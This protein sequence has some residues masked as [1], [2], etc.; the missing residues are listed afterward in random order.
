MKPLS[1]LLVTLPLIG[2]VLIVL[3]FFQPAFSQGTGPGGT[4][5][6]SDD[7]NRTGGLG[8][9]WTTY[10]GSFTTDGT[11]AIS[12]G[13]VNWAVVNASLGTDDYD[14]EALITVPSGASY[15]GIVARGNPA[16]GFVSDLYSAQIDSSGTVNLYR[17]NNYAWT[18]LSG[19]QAG[20]SAGQPY[21]LGLRVSGANPV[22][23]QVSLNG[24]SLFSFSDG[25]SLRLPSG[26]PGIENYTPE[27]KYDSFTVS[28]LSE[29][30]SPPSAQLSAI[31]T[32]GT[33][34]LSVQFDGTGSTD[35]GGTI[36]S[37]TWAFGD[38]ASA[39]GP[40]ASHTYS[41]PG[42]YTAS[43]TVT[44][45]NG[46]AGAS[47]TTIQVGSASN[48]LFSDDFNRTAGLGDAWVVYQGTFTADG[49]FALSQGA[50]NWAAIAATLGTNDYDVH[51]VLTIPSGSFYSGIVARGNPATGF[52]ADL[53]SAQLNST[54]EV[55]LYRRNNYTWTFLSG[56]QAGV[57][58]G[59]PYTLDLRVSGT[60]PVVLQVSLN[61][62]SLFSFSDASALR[63]LSGIPGLE[64]YSSNVKYD[65]FAVTALTATPPPPPSARVSAIPTS[66]TAPLSVQFDGTG[67]TDTGGT[68]G[69]YTWAFGDGA[70]AAGPTASHT[71]SIP[72]TYTASLTV[73]DSNGAA[74][75]ASVPISVGPQPTTGSGWILSQVPGDLEG[76]HFLDA[77][78]GWVVGLSMG[79]FK[80]TDGA[81]SWVSQG[82]VVWKGTAPAIPPNIYDVFFIDQ[83]TGWAV[84]WPELILGTTDG[85][86]TWVEQNLN[87][88]FTDPST[89][90]ATFAS[91][92]SCNIYNGVYLRRVRF[93]DPNHGFAVGRF[94]YV[95]KTTNGGATWILMSQ[96][97]PNLLPDCIEATT[98]NVFHFTVY[99]PHLFGLDMLSANELFVVGGDAGSIDCPHW[100]NVIAHSS[101]GGTTWDF[102]YDLDRQRRFMD[103][104]FIQD[105]GWAV[106]EGGM[107]MG[108]T[109]HGKT[110]VSADPNRAIT[111]NDLLGLAFPSINTIWA[112]GSSG[113]II[114]SND[115]G[116]TFVNQNS[117]TTLRLQRVWFTD[118]L[119]GW[120]AGHLGVV[121][122]TATGGE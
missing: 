110:W 92:G 91:D 107:I 89:Y 105:T 57:S 61:G 4:P 24:K 84:G 72:G 111:T 70:S 62:K 15:S 76:V 74:G 27:V 5:I 60:N 104:H 39:A 97:W 12:Q 11:F 121:P 109:D 52:N 118:T 64:S 1:R 71:Y 66:G 67:S 20:V 117:Q 112:V 33:A 9:N 108:S 47:Q 34:P 16:T 18:F 63:L 69:S 51:A 31:P 3:G 114:Y 30:P 78:N 22:V 90:C 85:G 29:T 19:T 40:T 8:A 54:G 14:L 116:K 120:A 122:R 113:T 87:R 94:G 99:A 44:D 88:A 106:G 68:I 55:N 6:F 25:S 35:T 58:A 36:G 93:A 38:G 79:I 2:A 98:G 96:N 101:D 100:E 119:H 82:N 7:F 43:L 37:Y 28:F 10:Q 115:G 26:L 53:Y 77:D 73:T 46:L 49:N 103:I 50:D 42:T 23:L 59:Q 48:L 75:V 83:N 21:T 41:I 56:T 65:S 17:R 32:S 81:G 102:H 95:Y 13:P 45:S 86:R 80:S